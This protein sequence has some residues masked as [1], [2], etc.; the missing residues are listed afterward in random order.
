MARSKS[1]PYELSNEGNIPLLHELAQ[2]KDSFIEKVTQTMHVGLLPGAL[3]KLKT[4]IYDALNNKLR[5]YSPQLD[6]ILVGYDNVALLGNG[7]HMIPGYFHIHVNVKAD[8]YVFNP[9]VGGVLT[10][11]VLTKS[12]VTATCLTNKVFTV[13]VRFPPHLRNSVQL[14]QDISFTIE[15]VD[16][17]SQIPCVTGVLNADSVSLEAST[18]SSESHMRFDEDAPPRAEPDSGLSSIDD[19]VPAAVSPS[20]PTPPDTS[21]RRR[22]RSRAEVDAP[23]P[24]GADVTPRKRKR[25]SEAD[26]NDTLCRDADRS[27]RERYADTDSSP[28]KKRIKREPDAEAEL[29]LPDP[30]PRGGGRRGG[31]RE[32]RD[33]SRRTM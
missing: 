28:R 23:P 26:A 5:Q 14:H 18:A 1:L 27:R 19:D 33:R 9:Q 4:G 15:K 31:P 10:G 32:G 21:R 8:F 13:F 20:S 29:Y 16:L 11:T 3:G 12:G 7:G 2:K 25:R 30:A 17:L 22:K 24:P 6:G